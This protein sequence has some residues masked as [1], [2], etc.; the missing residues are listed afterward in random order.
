MMN[1]ET[2]T[3]PD[4]RVQLA[5]AA[6]LAIKRSPFGS[7]ARA[8]KNQLWRAPYHAA[9]QRG[10]QDGWQS[11]AHWLLDEADGSILIEERVLRDLATRPNDSIEF[12]LLLTEL[13][14]IVLFD[15]TLALEGPVL[16]FLVALVRQLILNEYVY[17]E[18]EQEK[19][20]IKTLLSGGGSAAAAPQDPTRLALWL[21]L[22]RPIPSFYDRISE[23]MLD[24]VIARP[25]AELI[26]GLEESP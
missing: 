4:F 20:R 11:A 25:L 5:H 6:K 7:A 12:E 16:G 17:F 14:R 8:L 19:D 15:E 9:L 18:T 23:A 21:S 26:E 3:Y 1:Y 22:Y 2:E 13:R 24:G 10:R